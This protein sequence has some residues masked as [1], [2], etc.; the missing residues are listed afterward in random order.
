MLL[1]LQDYDYTIHYCPSKE[2][3]LPD[4]L[5]WFSPCPGPDILLDITIHHACLSPERKETFQQAF[6]SDPKM[7]A[8]TDMIIAGWHDD[9]KV[10]LIHYAHTGIIMRPSLLK[11]ALPFLE[12]PSS[13]LHQKGKG[14]YSNSTSSIKEPPKPSC[15]CMDVSSGWA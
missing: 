3:A 7:H 13:S 4:T 10:V 12:K 11:M 15:L 5:S 2:M 9:I 6:V 1:H 8:L 14:Y